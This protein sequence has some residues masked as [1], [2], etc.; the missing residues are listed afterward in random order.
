MIQFSTLIKKFGNQGEKTGWTYIDIPAKFAEQLI[1]GNKKSFRV[2]GKLDELPVKAIALIPMGGG[3]FIMA[4]NTAL[5]KNLRKR[6]GDTL[7]V[8]LQVDKVPIQPQPELVDCLKDEP[9]AID[10]FNKLKGSYRNY[11]IKWIDAVKSD[12][13]KAKRIAAVV[14]AMV[15]GY[16]FAQMLNAMK[17]DKE[18]LK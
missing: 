16:D 8:N 3:D 1:A 9:I 13:A 7:I 15:R 14:N 18:L 17:K 11:F 10:A 12:N 5:R 4:L 6:K 2:K